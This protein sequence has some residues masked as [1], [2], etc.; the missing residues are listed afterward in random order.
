MQFINVI[1]RTSKKAKFPL[2][3]V[4]GSELQRFDM[5]KKYT[6][7]VHKYMKN[8]GDTWTVE[9]LQK[10]IEHVVSPD[11]IDLKISRMDKNDRVSGVLKSLFSFIT[12]I[13]ECDT[14]GKNVQYIPLIQFKPFMTALLEGFEMRLPLDKSGR[15][16]TQKVTAIHETRHLFDHLCSPKISVFRSHKAVAYPPDGDV[17]YQK[18]FNKFMNIPDEKIDLMKFRKEISEELEKLPNDLKIE[19]LIDVRN[20][21]KSEINAYS[22]EIRFLM[23]NPIKNFIKILSSRNTLKNNAGFEKKLKIANTLLKETISKVR[24]EMRKKKSLDL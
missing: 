23:G 1:T 3:R 18:V 12:N 6:N 17:M 20:N 22:Q 4:R 11:E 24:S 7:Q 2:S 9:N 19:L 13:K 16:I 21:L 5:A 14:Q 10:A 8:T 15:V